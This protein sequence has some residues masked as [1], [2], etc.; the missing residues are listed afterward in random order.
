MRAHHLQLGRVVLEARA[1]LR[2]LE[3]VVLV[4][5]DGDRGAKRFEGA[6]QPLGAGT[7]RERMAPRRQLQRA[8]FDDRN[9]VLRVV[10]AVAARRR[11]PCRRSMPRRRS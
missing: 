3:L 11:A 5:P 4:A 6:G 1:D 8:P 9:A 10:V 7:E 2:P